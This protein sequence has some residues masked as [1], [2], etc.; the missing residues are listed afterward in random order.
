MVRRKKIYQTSEDSYI[1]HMR[2]I[3]PCDEDGLRQ[4]G[5]EK[6]RLPRKPYIVTSL[7]NPVFMQRTDPRSW[8]AC[9]LHILGRDNV[10]EGAF[11]EFFTSYTIML[12][13]CW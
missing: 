4:S 10:E 13:F 6:G 7:T 9:R 5:T 11:A 3:H 2:E 12:R 8:E 1:A